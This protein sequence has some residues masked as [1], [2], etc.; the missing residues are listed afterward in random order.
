MQNLEKKTLN[1]C[2]ALHTAHIAPGPQP[3]CP[4]GL[5]VLGRFYDSGRVVPKNCAHEVK[6]WKKDE[7]FTNMVHVNFVTS[8]VHR[9]FDATAATS[10]HRAETEPRH[11]THASSFQGG[12]VSSYSYQSL[13]AARLCSTIDLASLSRRSIWG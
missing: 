9:H 1:A 4:D 12:G 2:H 3:T 11:S 7:K 6:S 8:D 5:P 13:P 10:L